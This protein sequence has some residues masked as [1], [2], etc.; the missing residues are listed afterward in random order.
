MMQ[1]YFK[2]YC[3][4]N[5]NS[6]RLNTIAQFYQNTP[7]KP[8]LTTHLTEADLTWAWSEYSNLDHH[9]SIRM[10]AEA[11]ECNTSLL[12]SRLMVAYGYEYQQM[13]RRRCFGGD[14]YRKISRDE[15]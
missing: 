12:R 11:L 4:S 14:L 2:L 15:S 7:D 9:V 8:R 6:N 13:A 1:I 5:M 10:L 3:I